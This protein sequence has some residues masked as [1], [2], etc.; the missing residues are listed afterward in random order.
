[1][2]IGKCL[3]GYMCL[4]LLIG[5]CARGPAPPCKPLPEDGKERVL[6]VQQ[7]L[8][9]FGFPVGTLDGTMNGDTVQALRQFQN[10]RGLP[11]NGE[12]DAQT[13]EALGFCQASPAKVATSNCLDLPSDRREQ[14]KTV[15]RL[16]AERGYDPGSPDG[17]MGR[18][19]GQALKHFQAANGL[20][21][22]GEVDAATRQAFGFCGQAVVGQPPSAPQ[23]QRPAND[24]QLQEAQRLLAARGYDPGP[25]DGLMG[26]KT[27][28]ALKRF[29]ADN[30][31]LVSGKADAQTLG[32][33]RSSSSAKPEKTSLG[34]GPADAV[35][36]AQFH[37]EDLAAPPANK[38][39]TVGTPPPSSSA[40]LKDAAGSGLPPPPSSLPAP[41][42]N[43]ANAEGLPPP[44][45]P[46]PS[47][48]AA[49]GS[50]LPPPSSPLALSPNKADA[51]GLP[52]PS[53]PP[54]P[55]VGN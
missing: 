23:E 35:P 31:L 22:T 30:D 51:E 40:P 16:L 53:T 20:T 32:V 2:N 49:A 34:P 15:Q 6:A 19:T 5:A 52:P 14:I 12:A 46:S 10:Y 29:Q 11:E 37:E 4:L 38:A 48:D 43:K 18:K 13:L 24:S 41:P 33:L 50:D 27:R 54:P 55:V 17:Q 3:A 8:V 9:G 39:D 45:L 7:A 1:M 25:A 36:S 47:K 44:S 42:P 21:E 28:E 26:K